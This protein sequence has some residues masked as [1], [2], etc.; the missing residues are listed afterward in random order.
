MTQITQRAGTTRNQSA[1]DF[2]QKKIFIWDNKFQKGVFKNTTGSSMTLSAGMFVARNTA[3]AGG[4]I[5][6]TSANFQDS[7]GVAAIEDDIT[8]ANNATVTISFCTGGGVDANSLVLPA[9]VT[10]DSVPASGTKAF[11]DILEGEGLHLDFTTVEN[12]KFDN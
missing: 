7:I 3:I 1:A 5:P 6:V 9:S 2:Q 8:L 11:R 4:L 10:F 12:T